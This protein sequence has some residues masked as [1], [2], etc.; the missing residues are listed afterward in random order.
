[1]TAGISYA[2]SNN[3]IQTVTHLQ[4]ASS[5]NVSDTVTVTTYENLGSNKN[6]GLNLNMNIIQHKGSEH[7]YKCPAF[8]CMAEGN[9]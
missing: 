1:M 2:F 7:Q 9:L 3:S 6:L 8:P 5:G 4:A